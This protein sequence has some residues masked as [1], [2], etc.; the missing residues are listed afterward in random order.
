[1]KRWKTTQNRHQDWC[2]FHGFGSRV[3]E[4]PWNS[5]R[6]I[7]VF[8]WKFTRI[9]KMYQRIVKYWGKIFGS[10]FLSWYYCYDFPVAK[11]TMRCLN[12]QRESKQSVEKSSHRIRA[13]AVSL[14]FLLTDSRCFSHGKKLHLCLIVSSLLTFIYFTYTVSIV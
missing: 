3:V 1:M 10:T 9:H 2:P 5:Q 4:W 8:I 6:N 11:K 13:P 12:K 14:P 7:S